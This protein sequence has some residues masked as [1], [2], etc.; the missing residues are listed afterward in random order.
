MKEMPTHYQGKPEEVLA[1]DTYIKLN[2]ATS[3]FEARMLR[4]DTLE[5]LTLS[6][7]G[8]LEALHHMGSLCQGV[9]SQKLLTSTGNMTLV[10]DNLEKR[11]LVRRVRSVEDRRMI[12]IELTALGEETIA[13][14]FPL[15]VQAI[16]QEMSVLTPAEQNELGRLLRKLGRG[17]GAESS[18]PAAEITSAGAGEAAD[19]GL[20]AV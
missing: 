19:A 15:H 18:A 4:H 10:L 7:F 20:T 3:A 8:V 2:R 16:T 9:L 5:E 17:K 12:K 13:R 6:Q 11:G 1:L 14:I